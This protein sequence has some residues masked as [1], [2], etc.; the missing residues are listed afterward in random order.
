MLCGIF[1]TIEFDFYN[2]KW[3][4]LFHFHSLG[5]IIWFLREKK[6]IHHLDLHTHTH[7]S[8]YC[9]HLSLMMCQIKTEWRPDKL[10]NVEGKGTSG[11]LLYCCGFR[12]IKL[13]EIFQLTPKNLHT[14]RNWILIWKHLSASFNWEGANSV[15]VSA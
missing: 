3:D 15:H 1:L 6:T 2:K 5:E 13:I 10:P 8:N 4:L 11:V 9:L 7:I 14:K 12:V